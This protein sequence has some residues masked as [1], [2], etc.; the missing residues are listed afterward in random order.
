MSPHLISVTSSIIPD[1]KDEDIQSNHSLSGTTIKPETTSLFT[2]SD[3]ES[4]GDQPLDSSGDSFISSTASVMPSPESQKVTAPVEL[5]SSDTSKAAVIA[6]S[7]L[8]ST[9]KP[10]STVSSLY[11]TEKPTVLPAEEQGSA[12]TDQTERPSITA[13]TDES[14]A[15]TITDEDGSGKQKPDMFTQTSPITTTSSLLSTET[16]TAVTGKPM[17]SDRTEQTVMPS[18]EPSGSP[19][20]DGTVTHSTTMPPHLVSVTSSTISDT[21]DKDILS[22]SISSTGGT[23]VKPETKPVYTITDT[24]SSGDESS[25]SIVTDEESSGDQTTDPSSRET[26]APT[27]SSLFSTEKPTVLPIEEQD[28]AFTVQTETP[29]IT[30]ITDKTEEISGLTQTDKNGSGEQTP[31]VFT[32]TSLISATSSLQSTETPSKVTVKT[33]TID[34]SG[35]TVTPSPSGEASV[36]PISAGTVTISATTS[37]H[38]IYVTSSSI[39]DTEDEDIQKKAI[40]SISGTTTQPETTSLF[41]ISDGESSGD[42]PLDSSGDSFISSTASVMPSIES[43]TVTTPAELQSSD[44]SKA[45]VTAVSSLFSTEKPTSTVSSLYSTEKP[46]VLTSGEQDSAVT[47]QTE[48]PSIT[49]ETDESSG[50]PS[51]DENGSGEQLTDIVTQTSRPPITATSSLQSTETPTAVTGKPMESD[52]TGRTVMPSREPSVS[53]VSDGTVTHS[54]TMSPH[55]VSVT[56]ATIPDTKDGDI[57]SKP[58]HSTGGTT[59][60][61]E[62]TPV[63]I[64]TDTE[65]SGEESSTSIDTDEESSGDRATDPSSRETVAPTSSSLFSTEKPTGLP[66]DEQDSAFTGQTETPSITFITDKTEESSG[67]TPTDGDGSGEH[68]PD[69]FTQTSLISAKASL[70]STE[71]PSTVTGRTMTVDATGETVTPSPS[72]KASVYPVSDGTETHSATMSPH[73][74][75]VTSSTIADTEDED[76]LSKSI[77]ST[78]GTTVKPGT[79]PVY[80]ITD[81][82]SS[83]EESLTSIVTDEESSGDQTTDPSSRETAV[84]TASSL[85][86]TE[87]PTVLPIDEQDSAFTVQTETHS[88]TFITEKTEESTGLTPTDEDGSGEQTPDVFTQTSLISATSSL[89]STETPTAVTG[90]PMESDAAEQ[91]VMPSRE[92]SVSPVSDGTVTHSTT[93]S[94]RLVSVTSSTIPDTEDEDIQRKAIHSLSGTTIKPETTSL[95]TISDVESSGDQPLDSS[96]ES[97]ISS[98]ATVMPSTESLTVTAPAELESSDTSE[99]AVTAVSSLFSTEKPTSTVSSLY[100]T[101]KPTVLTSGEQDSAVTDQTETPSITAETDE[102]SGLPSTDEDGSGEQLTDIVTQTSPIT[103]TSS[104]QSTETPTAVTGK[105]SKSD[106]TVQTVI[107]SREPSV[108]PVSDGTVTHSTTMSPHLVSVTSSTISDTK[109]EDIVSESITSTDGTTVKPET[110]PVYTITDTESSGE[111]SSTS[112]VTDEESSGDQTTD[113]SFRETAA[114]TSFSLFSTEKPT[115]LPIEE[116]DRAF[117]GQTETPSNT[118]ITDKTEE[119]SGLTPTDEGGSGEQTPDEFTQASPITPTSSLQSTETPTAVTGKPMESDEAEQTVMP[120][121]EPSVSPVSDGTVTHSTTMSPRLVSVTSSTNPDTEDEDIQKKAIHSIS[122]TTTQPETTSL[123]TISDLESSGDQPLDS[124]GD[125]FISSTATVMPSTE[126]LTVTTPAELESSDTSKAAV[127]AVSSLFSTEKPTSTVSSLYS[128]EKPTVLT[129]GAQDSAV[130]DQ[131]QTPSIAAETDESSG[132]TS[133]DE[134]GSGEQL[135]DIVTQTSPITASSSLQS[136]ETPT[137]VTGKPMESDA[138]EQTV[139]P[140]RE[141]SVSPV[142]DG[143]VTHST[144]MSP[145]LVSVTSSTI[146]DTEDEDIQRK[147]IHSISGTTTQPETTSLFT[148][149]DVESSGDQPLDSSGDSFITSTATVMPSTESLTVTTPAELESSDTSKAAV[150]AVSSLFSTE[151]PTS[152]VSSLYST[153]KPTVLT[154]GEQDSAVTDQTQ[155]PSIAAE[156]DESSGF[157]LTDEDGSGEQ[158]TDIV[159]QTSPITATSSLQSTETPTAVTGKPMESD[160]T[161]QTVMPSREPSVSP[162]SDGT[163]THSSTMSPHLV[164]V[165]SSTISDTEDEDIVS[166]SITST[167]G[168]TVKPETKPVYTITD[169]ESSGEESSTSIDTDDESSGDQTT[170]P[171]TRETAAPTSFSLFS[172]EKPIVLPIEE[173]DRAFT[174]QTETPSNTFI[175]DKTEERSGLTPTDKDGSGEQTPDMFTQTSPITATSSLQNTETP[176]AVTGKPMESDAKEQTVMPSREPSVSPLSD[177]TVTQSTIIYPHLVS[178]TSST[179]PD[180]EDEDIQRKAI[181]YTSG[182]TTQPETTSLFTISDVESSGDQPLDSSGDSF[183]SS[184]A[185]VMPS[186]ESLTVTAPAELESSDT[187]KAAVTAVSSLFSTEKPTSTVSSLYSTEKPTVLTAEEQDSAVTDHTKTPSIAAKTDESSGLTSTDED[188]SGEQLT[189]MVT[190]TSPITTTSSLQST[191]TPTAV[192]GKSTESDATEQTVIPSREP[193]VSPVSIGTVAHSTTMSSH[194][195]SVTSSTIPDTEDKDIVSKSITSTGGTTVKPET[196]PVYTITDSESSGEE[197]STSI[198]TDEESSGDQITDPFTRETAAP[199][200]SSLFSTEKPTVLPI[201]EQD[202]AFTVQ[203]ETPSSTFITDKTEESSGLTP[204]DEDGSGE[205][206]PDVFTQTSL[207]SATSSLPSTDMPSTVTGT[208][209]RID[210][211]GETVTPSPSGEASVYP[212]SDGTETHS[213]TMSP[214]LISVTSSTIADTDDEEIQ[215]KAIHSISGTTTQP[216]TTSLF[217]ISDLESSGDQPLDSS[218][219]S[220]ISFTASVMPSTESQ[221]VTA[222]A[223]LESSDTSKAAVTAV[224]SLFSTEKPT[225]TVS[226]LYST[227]KPTVLTAE[228]QDSAVTDHTQTPSI[229]AKTDKSSG[230]TSTDEDGSG[231]QLTDMVT[232]TSPITTTSSLQST[233]TPTAV[234]GKPTESDATEQTVIPSREPSVSPVSIGTVAHSTTMSPHLVSVTSSTISDTKDE[235]IVSESI[236]STDG[237]TVKPETTP[238]YTITD[239]ESSGEESSTSIDTDKESSGDQTTDPSS[240]E[241][242]DPTSSSQ[243]STEKPTVLPIDEQDSAFTVQTETPSITFITDKTE[244]SSGLTPTDEDGS[245]EQTPDV[246]TQTSLI[247]ATSSLQSTETP[248]TVTVKTMTID[249]TGETVKPSPSGEASLYPSPDGTV[250]HSAT[251]SP[252]LISVTSSTIADTEDEDIQRKAIHSTGRTTVK[253]E[254]TPV[255]TITDTESTGYESLTSIITDEESSGDRMSDPS[256]SE[257]ASS[258]ASSLSSTEK[259][260]NEDE[261]SSKETV[262]V[263]TSFIFVTEKTSLVSAEIGTTFQPKLSTST[264]GGPEGSPLSV[265]DIT[266]AESQTFQT[267]HIK[268]TLSPDKPTAITIIDESETSSE[269]T[270]TKEDSSFGQTTEMLTED[271]SVHSLLPTTAQTVGSDSHSAVIIGSYHEA[272][273]LASTTI[274]SSVPII[275]DIESGFLTDLTPGFSSKEIRTDS[276]V[277]AASSLYSTEEPPSPDREKQ[278]RTAETGRVSTPTSGDERSNKFTTADSTSSLFSTVRPVSTTVS[279]KHATFQ[280]LQT[281]VTSSIHSTAI[282]TVISVITTNE[283]GSGDQTSM[284]QTSPVTVSSFISTASA[285]PDEEVDYSFST[286]FTLVESLPTFGITTRRPTS[287]AITTDKSL[288]TDEEGSADAATDQS[289][290]SSMFSTETPA[291]MFDRTTENIMTH[292]T[293]FTVETAVTV[294]SSLYS[295][296]KPRSVSPT[297]APT[298]SAKTSKDVVLTTVS[299][300][301]TTEKSTSKQSIDDIEEEGSSGF[302]AL[303]ESSGHLSSDRVTSMLSTERPAT[304]KSEELTTADI[305]KGSFTSVSS[306]YS[307]DRLTSASPETYT[308]DEHSSG[309]QTTDP[310]TRETATPTASSLFSTEKP[311]VL[312]IEEQDSA[313]TVQTETP[314]ITFITNKSEESSG[315][316]SF[317]IADTEDEDIQRK[318]I[319]SLS[320]TTIKP[321]T[322]SLF[323]ISDLESSGDQPLYSSGES[324]ISFTAYVMPSTESQ[325]VT[326]PAELESSD[327]SKAAVTAVSSLFSTEKPTSTVSS[328]FSTE[329]PT[330]LPLQEQDS[331]IADQTE[332]PVYT[333]IDTESSG[334]ESSTSIVTGEESSGDQTTDPSSR[335]T[336]AST[337]SSL[338]ST[339]KPTVLPI[340]EQDSAF[341]V[342]TETPSITFITDKTEESSGFT[343]TDEGDSGEQTPDVFTQTSLISATSSLQSTETPTTV[344]VKTMTTNLTGEIVTPSPSG[345]ASVSTVSDGTVTHSATMSPHLISVTSSTIADT[346]DEDNQRKAIYSISGTTTQPGTTS[347]FTI[348]DL[349]SSGDQPF[350]SSGDSFISST[351]SVMPSTE[352]LT[353]TAHV[354]LESSDTSKAAVTEVSSLFSTEKPTSTV[355]SLFSTEKPTVLPAETPVI[356][357]STDETDETSGLTAT[358]EDGSRDQRPDVVVHTS[359]V[360][361]TSSMQSTMTP[362]AVTGKTMKTGATEQTMMGSGDFNDR[363]SSGDGTSVVGLARAP[364]AVTISSGIKPTSRDETP[365]ETPTAAEQPTAGDTALAPTTLRPLITSTF[366][367]EESMTNQTNIF[368]R[369][370]TT[371]PPYILP[372]SD[373]MAIPKVSVLPTKETSTYVDMESSGHS[374]EDDDSETSP[375][376][377]GSGSGSGETITMETLATDETEIDETGTTHEIISV[378]SPSQSSTKPPKELFSTASPRVT[379][380]ETYFGEQGSGA[381][382]DDSVPEEESSG[383]EFHDRSITSSSV[384]ST[385]IAATLSSSDADFTE[386]R[387]DDKTPHIEDAITLSST[388][389]TEKPMMTTASFAT[390][391]TTGPAA[392]SLYSTEK[393]TVMPPQKHTPTIQGNLTDHSFDMVTQTL[394]LSASSVLYNTESPT[395]GLVTTSMGVTDKPVA[396]TLS[397]TVS[398]TETS[399]LFT[400]NDGSGDQATD[401]LKEAAS[402]LFSTKEPLLTPASHEST[403]APAKQDILTSVSSLFSTEKLELSTTPESGASIAITA[404]LFYSTEKPK[405]TTIHSSSISP[406]ATPAVTLIDVEGSGNET[407]AMFTSEPSTIESVTFGEA[408]GEMETF[409]SVTQSSDEQTAL[410]EGEIVSEI[411]TTIASKM[412]ES[413]IPGT[414]KDEITVAEDATNASYTT[415][416]HH[417]SVGSASDNYTS[418]VTAVSSSG[419]NAPEGISTPIPSITY[420]GVTD[421]QVMII[422]PSSSQAMTDLTEQ[423]PTMVLHVSKA[424][425]STTIIFTEDAKDEDEIFSTGTDGVREQSPTSELSSKD[426]SIIDADT[427]SMVPSSSFFPTIQTEEAEGV[428]AVTMT[429]KFQLT[430]EPEGSGT[431][432]N[433][434]FTPTPVTLY[435]PSDL[436]EES[437]SSE[438]SL[439]TSTSSLAEGV[440]SVGTVTSLPETTAAAAMSRK[441]SS[442]EIVNATRLYTV[443]LEGDSSDEDITE[444][445]TSSSMPSEAL[446]ESMET[447]THTPVSSEEYIVSIDEKVKYINMS[448]TDIPTGSSVSKLSSMRPFTDTSVP[449]ESSPVKTISKISDDDSSGDYDSEE[450]FAVVTSTLGSKIFPTT[451]TSSVSF[452]DSENTTASLVTVPATVS[453]GNQ[454]AEVLNEDESV[455]SS[456]STIKE[457]ELPQ[458]S[459]VSPVFSTEKSGH[460]VTTMSNGIAT[461][462]SGK[463]VTSTASSLFSTEKPTDASGFDEKDED[464]SVDGSMFTEDITTVKA[465]DIPTTSPVRIEGVE[466]ITSA[467]PSLY[468]TEKPSVSD[469]EIDSSSDQTPSKPSAKTFSVTSAELVTRQTETVTSG[470]ASSLYTTKKPTTSPSLDGADMSPYISTKEPVTE[471]D[472]SLYS[473]MKTDEMLST[474]IEYSTEKPSI[475][476]ILDVGTVEGS[477]DDISDA[478]GTITTT[479]FP[480]AVTPESE[481]T[482]PTHP[483]LSSSAEKPTTTQEDETPSSEAK[484][485]E[486]KVSLSEIPTSTDGALDADISTNVSVSVTTSPSLH[487]TSQ[488]DAMIQFVTTF[489]PE[490]DATPPE[491]SFQQARSEIAFT[492]HPRSDVSSMETIVVTTSPMLPSEESSQPHAS[493]VIP[494]TL[495][496]STVDLTAEAIEEADTKGSAEIDFSNA[497]STAAITLPAIDET[498]DYNGTEA[499]LIESTILTD[500]KTAQ[501]AEINE[502]TTAI[503]SMFSTEKPLMTTPSNE[504]YTAEIAVSAVT[505]SSLYSTEEPVSVIGDTGTSSYLVKE[506][507]AIWTDQTTQPA[508][509]PIPSEKTS[510]ESEEI[511]A[512]TE[513]RHLTE[514]EGSADFSSGDISQVTTRPGFDERSQ[515]SA[516]TTT[517]PAVSMSVVMSTSVEYGTSEPTTIDSLGNNID[518]ETPDYEATYLVESTPDIIRE[519]ESTSTHSP[520]SQTSGSQSVD[521]E[522]STES[523][524]YEKATESPILPAA[525]TIMPSVSEPKSAAPSSSEISSSTSLNVSS[526][527]STETPSVASISHDI[528]K[529]FMKE[530]STSSPEMVT[531]QSAQAA[532]SSY[533]TDESNAVF[534]TATDEDGFNYETPDPD[535]LTHTISSEINET[536]TTI[537]SMFSTEKPLMTTPS[538]ENYTAEI[539]VSA[540]TASSLYSTEEPVSVIGDT[541]TSSYLAKEGDA[542]WTD[543]TT[544]PASS[545]IPSEKTSVE[546]EEISAPT[547]TRHLTE[548]E[549]SADFSSG[550]ISQV[551]NR[552]GFDERS[553]KSAET[554]TVPAVSMSV[555]MSTSVEYGTSEP[556]TID[557]L[558]NNID[559][560][561]PDY[562]ATYLVESTPDIIRESESTS[563]HS[564]ISQTSGSQS[565]DLESSTESSSYEKATESPIL[566]AAITIMPSVSEPKSAAPSSS[567]ISS[568]TSLNVSS[569]FS[570]ETPSVASISH[571]IEKQFM[572]ETSTSSPE[573]VTEQSAQAAT[574]PSSSESSSNSEE[575]G[576]T[577]TTPKQDS[578]KVEDIIPELSAATTT[579]PSV[580]SAITEKVS[581]SS[582]SHSGKTMTTTKTRIDSTEEY[583]QSPHEIDTVFKVNATTASEV[584][585]VSIGR[586][587]DGDDVTPSTEIPAW[588]KMGLT[589]V[590]QSQPFAS[591]TTTPSSSSE[592]DVDTDVTFPTLTEGELPIKGE[593]TTTPVETGLGLGHPVVGETVEIP[594]MLIK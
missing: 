122:G 507:D 306:L 553:Q 371:T 400:E 428:T 462:A 179:N 489:V 115:V 108:S 213:A 128:T 161:E 72:E 83:G 363:E 66:I 138:T 549:G 587:A 31:D 546:S 434:S 429:Q 224:S 29:S 561:T 372:T 211:T 34:S 494:G 267:Q 287:T 558:G 150:T 480:K 230:L 510:V 515:K 130:T 565:V 121:R 273:T 573:M 396:P 405:I 449:A 329:K 255:Y 278:S 142:S 398:L 367:E 594:G 537:S 17:E 120:S 441:S 107:P 139:M 425:T 135:T 499:T 495:A 286:D 319:H 504:N 245:G 556:T 578:H 175:T 455:L 244:E 10:T 80:T 518:E 242:A 119:S 301:H 25:A 19:V 360:T 265:T 160:A 421:Q 170:D 593:E 361:A 23:T 288:F 554:T 159:T 282:P 149:S 292:K 67:L 48:T 568:S 126:S 465:D 61:P 365:L 194:L 337:A 227:E 151:K 304:T 124:S 234:T 392:S 208:T 116:Q 250:T 158:L 467:S 571:D 457:D 74:I 547:E 308:S 364:G 475:A 101:E 563:T 567:E 178:I 60:K 500:D 373:P 156:T 527:F 442:E 583:T 279:Y 577:E 574:T 28:S 445:A 210:A 423:T 588:E 580:L 582:E 464:I 289:S 254:T 214:H 450:G 472:A 189:D 73:L 12:V 26:A 127:T 564:P 222:P 82:G 426:D 473:T 498:V 68:T 435:T 256:T 555:V 40:H 39:A 320:G 454:T 569:L 326:A 81:T 520:I 579:S 248:S 229:A 165:T 296:E 420:H 145:H 479:A 280:S 391:K 456:F 85:F 514:E 102:S 484:I 492:H 185:S 177:G 524:S 167:D 53:Q 512:P 313:L 585:S 49:A 90:K 183:I 436:S 395:V 586:D 439:S 440:S 312:P 76:I 184:T 402:S 307:T 453:S 42:Q 232:Q 410:Q 236:T 202:S 290:V 589:T 285:Q 235:D 243:F 335:E 284:T 172:T 113:Q 191:E 146:S 75:P 333:V 501:G 247:S 89:Q 430:I 533:G 415:I 233:E 58:I 543:Q 351:A 140:S 315:L 228:E 283:E 424:S 274:K 348:S 347:L 263:A 96:G 78:G 131:T 422:T 51:T 38:L 384:V 106:A 433:T 517:V 592:E 356:T 370:T 302:T 171:S 330:V 45:A 461:V 488:P 264:S 519:S 340:E 368:I 69:V 103:A 180:T 318:A 21:E 448:T 225:S 305:S 496:T 87:K 388:F 132:F 79:T 522:S 438:Y 137:A 192:T 590:T 327:T 552:P 129:A 401:I 503:S 508:S 8:F 176:T 95:F 358:D 311:T 393:S 525:I 84:P 476:R 4:S 291:A 483:S 297:S 511:S 272:A 117:T 516:E 201:D 387:S 557:Y 111:E 50:L 1:I 168:T 529:Q 166:K 353:M 35:K 217:T 409:V 325:T 32:Q 350:D 575:M 11:S 481:K 427:V 63:Y 238:V 271:S 545:P 397:S 382:T 22:K 551:T 437:S 317:T 502:T 99:A 226:S 576:A 276:S 281:D 471:I 314:S 513:T 209:M 239:T 246:F 324:V 477:G 535:T 57:L 322:T 215:R 386:E 417:A 187:S 355:S 112:I 64:I 20:S 385:T 379:S 100:S 46:T 490:P 109:D 413:P 298:S 432:D 539:A 30:F 143:T 148:I 366:V 505:A 341:T 56:S 125:S 399:S 92:P 570:T 460:T 359:P 262:T 381:F 408:T 198:V 206:T 182:T 2:I 323:T 169:T 478:V 486:D 431:D 157:T 491:D 534:S 186:T 221:T 43:L 136:T 459:T 203:T 27:A 562:E 295:T 98:T 404:S 303:E 316:T 3:V 207:I 338:F 18:R 474:V 52:A 77:T 275:D 509:S 55:L 336:A 258:T 164:S 259:P 378:A 13:E 144:T 380:N 105:P 374:S 241:T 560:E 94:P 71:T 36:S 199:T 153:E 123:F 152:T 97:F 487:P 193:S 321:E 584:A 300:L 155:T 15:P 506:G 559:E 134:D 163:V 47:D 541:G 293:S 41:T 196:T 528:E 231:E 147:A 212:V 406:S 414:L 251:M 223:E 591:I 383:V 162:V 375:D 104:L 309:D 407:S 310:S 458:T 268:K 389:T 377:S 530:T 44:T 70:Q 197:G 294:A 133:T 9:E 466:S 24:E 218:G 346:E 403:S 531:E 110:T 204:T 342:Q 220:F 332:T 548:E 14:S 252:H 394:S 362:P 526:L 257:T 240:R 482:V 277:T 174:G 572:K 91:T 412:A 7:S 181:H 497:T 357:S 266:V 349:E 62:T 418:D 566:P 331:A 540:V 446:T 173:Q 343:P 260:K 523:S 352:S 154:A 536:T 65:S 452:V 205:Q 219:D 470:A 532:T 369:A 443:T 451:E 485:Q 447:S 141:P 339:E 93:M 416:S 114:P 411:K 544:Q 419:E 299:S 118:F 469:V 33:M 550:D 269:I 542:I 261:D 521:S 345:E 6:V 5:E 270:S 468:S 249:A 188:G 354:E 390:Q 334:E 463:P 59:V 328:L 190:Q 216:E 581:L 200:A 195:V 37:P 444:I 54:T 16:P 253:P 88:I 376:G 344:T 86:S 237:T 493:S 538:N